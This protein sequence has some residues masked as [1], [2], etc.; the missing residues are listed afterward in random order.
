MNCNQTRTTSEKT[1]KGNKKPNLVREKSK[2][3][4]EK[5]EIYILLTISLYARMLF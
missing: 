2:V 4:I 1:K 5:V 3:Q